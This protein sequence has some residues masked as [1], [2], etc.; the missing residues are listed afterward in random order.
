MDYLLQLEEMET[1]LIKE[2]DKVPIILNPNDFEQYKKAENL[3]GAINHIH[4]LKNLYYGN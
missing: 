4:K 2:W 1:E 3:A